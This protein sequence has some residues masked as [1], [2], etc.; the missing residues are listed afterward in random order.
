MTAD[1]Y[2]PHLRRLICERVSDFPL[3]IAGNLVEGSGLWLSVWGDSRL[4]LSVT[5]GV[6]V[7]RAAP[8][9]MTSGKLCTMVYGMILFIVTA[10]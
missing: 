1:R 2:G 3:H 9:I 7:T 10:R 8:A 6:I 5:L 4:A